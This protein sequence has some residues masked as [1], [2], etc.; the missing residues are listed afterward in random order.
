MVHHR[1]RYNLFACSGI[2]YNH[3]SPRRPPQFVTRKISLA[4]AAIKLGLRSSLAIG[5]LKAKRDWGFAGDHVEAMWRM[6]QADSAEDYVICT[7]VLHTV[8]DLVAAAF[9]CVDLDWQKY[10]EVDPDLIREDEHFQ[11]VGNPDKAQQNL[12][13]EPQVSFEQLIEM[14]VQADVERLKAGTIAS[15]TAS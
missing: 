14:M 6:L 12:N 8:Q 11:L 1:D 5:N 9:S 7:G 15:V 2:L 4:A 10:A 3:E 13:W